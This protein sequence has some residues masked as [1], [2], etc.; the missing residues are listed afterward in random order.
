[1]GFPVVDLGGKTK[2]YGNL[3]QCA[4][5]PDTSALID[6]LKILVNL[7][8]KT[9]KAAS[10]QQK[11]IF[12]DKVLA[13]FAAIFQYLSTREFPH[14]AL[15]NLE[16][17]SF[18]PC[19][20]DKTLQWYTPTMVFFNNGN[21]KEERSD[22][23]DGITNSLFPTVPFSPFLS[24]T[25]V[26]QEATTKDLFS[27]I[28]QSPQAAYDAIKSEKR[29]RTLLRRIAAHRPFHRVDNAIRETPFLLAYTVSEDGDGKEKTTCELAKASDIYI[30]DNTFFGRMFSVKR[31]PHESD[32][33]EFYALI[34]ARYI[35]EVVHKKFDIIGRPHKSG[36]TDA[37]TER[38]QERG[39]LLV[40]PSV[41][42]RPLVENA[43][44]ILLPSNFAV[45]QVDEITVV[46]K[47]QKSVRTNNTTCC[48]QQGR[49]GRDNAVVITP[50]FEFFDVGYA[51]AEL[52]L[53]HPNLTD[54]FF[55][56]SLLE[57]PLDQLRARGFP[58][59]RIIKVHEPTKTNP[60]EPE[61]PTIAAE[62]GDNNE[63]TPST[64][65]NHSSDNT[66]N[67]NHQGRQVLNGSPAPLAASKDKE[68][69]G[70]KTKTFKDTYVSIL[71]QMFPGADE[72]F[73]A[74]LLG[75]NP[76]MN[77]VKQVAEDL[78]VNGY[79]EKAD[80][81]DDASTVTTQQEEVEQER[82]RP[83][84]LLGSKKLSRAFNGLK[85]GKN[86]GGLQ[87]RLKQTGAIS[88]G[89]E[90]GMAAPPTGDS[91]APQ[92]PVQPKDDAT[93]QENMEK[94]LREKVKSSPSVDER[95]LK[96]P[97]Q[98]ISIPEGLD[99][100]SSC[101]VLPSQD[102][103]PFVALNGK[104]TSHNG[105]KIFSYAKLSSSEEHLQAHFDAVECFAVVLER[106]CTVVF[107]LPLHSVAICK[108]L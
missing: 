51:I 28:I 45:L 97:E 90:A 40:S 1:M 59:D 11:Q 18:I 99:H 32:L 12:C 8:K 84:K 46:Y 36:I 100:G 15:R 52:I 14:H 39:P 23:L 82:S 62:K 25:G 38:I 102:I 2:L 95:G 35:S 43:A 107:G 7:S 91:Q 98:S 69:E 57:A 85:S 44:S 9:Y 21:T 73:I 26:K 76:N 10:Q 6:Q 87:N 47:L 96:T 27:L 72:A 54:A 60:E 49:F 93:L 42:S 41:T 75:D 22:D 88:F 94:A 34:G 71:K 105:I 55:I 64:P 89:N 3:F 74:Q 104:T 70:A 48:S 56:S 19:L 24:S 58:V 67:Q 5:E 80:A 29:Y 33:E 81:K 78:A 53:K 13:S 20:V 108:L 83:S 63:T 66:Q 30:I 79:P 4:E 65:S 68:E 37:L 103:K 86:L 61:T 77:K 16:N 50:D 17:E 101:E 106:L 31:A 92:A